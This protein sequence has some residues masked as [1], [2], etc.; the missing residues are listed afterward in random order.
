MFEGDNDFRKI[1]TNYVK[2][3]LK[4]TPFRQRHKIQELLGY[5][6]WAVNGVPG[7]PGISYWSIVK[8]NKD[9]LAICKELN[10]TKYREAKRENAQETRS[11]IEGHKQWK[12]EKRKQLAFEKKT[13]TIAMKKL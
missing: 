3:K 4:A 10:P 13:W 8:N 9:F 7:A 11:C 1:K 12:R 5:E 6:R 2:E